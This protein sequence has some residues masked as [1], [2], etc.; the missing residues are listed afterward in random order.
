M[1]ESPAK[2]Q[3]ILSLRA[4][5]VE[6][7]PLPA[8][9]GRGA[10][11]NHLMK[12]VR[13]IFAACTAEEAAGLPSLPG[14]LDYSIVDSTWHS[15]TMPTIVRASS[16]ASSSS[17]PA[18]PA[19]TLPP[20]SPAAAGGPLTPV[21]EHRMRER[22]VELFLSSKREVLKKAVGPRRAREAHLAYRRRWEM[23][24]R[25][26]FEKCSADDLLELR[27]R[28]Q[29]GLKRA[30]DSHGLFKTDADYTED[31]RNDIDVVAPIPRGSS[32]SIK[33][34]LL[35]EF[36]GA[37]AS[38]S[39]TERRLLQSIAVRS[40]QKNQT[41]FQKARRFLGLGLTKSAWRRAGACP[42]LGRRKGQ[43]T[44][45]DKD[46]KDLLVDH[47]TSSPWVCKK[48][49][50]TMRT[51]GGSKRHLWTT[52]APVHE[53]CSLRT[54]YRRTAA[55][56]LGVTTGRTRSDL[57]DYCHRWDM[58]FRPSLQGKM[59]EWRLG[60]AALVTDFWE[61]HD[62]VMLTNETFKDGGNLDRLSYLQ[63]LIRFLQ[64]WAAS[65]A[66]TMAAMSMVQRKQVED[67][68]V[69][70]LSQLVGPDG[71]AEILAGMENHWSIRDTQASALLKDEAEPD[72]S[73]LY[74][75]WDFAD[76]CRNR[77]NT[78]QAVI[79]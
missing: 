22:M 64:G 77:K 37:M 8:G 28:V 29:S 16:A 34:V 72:P 14:W 9:L 63:F 71:F 43:H 39:T 3:A 35:K 13:L 31:M 48:L 33:K 47:T 19:P 76:S 62:I 57:C 5:I 69:L 27:G 6:L 2:R 4:S 38:A 55:A 42:R 17:M 65:R 23:P 52:V 44:A 45:P 49:G 67:F 25:I 61:G 40:L 41:S 59:S 78:Q 30:R 68:I 60:A 12:V 21:K 36:E 10:V 46:L 1:P 54:F 20:T 26:L 53:A 24:G 15:L 7:R 75:L 18:P 70:M 58:V 66:T 32:G 79:T 50:E 56:R 73:C 51:I 11:E 74:V